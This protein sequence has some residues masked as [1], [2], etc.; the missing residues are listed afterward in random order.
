MWL[1]LF[2]LL[3]QLIGFLVLLVAL[4]LVYRFKLRPT[5]PTVLLK[6]DWEKDV[7]YLCQFP[8]CPSVR[9]ISPFAL[10]LETWLKITGK[11]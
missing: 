10:K 5:P 1:W 2:S 4:L 3:L 6:K 8:L 11:V 7:V 9:S